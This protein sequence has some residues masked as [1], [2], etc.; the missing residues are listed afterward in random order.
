MS[1]IVFHYPVG[2]TPL[3][4]DEAQ[5]LIPAHLTTQ[6]QLNEWELRNILEAEEWA[7]S[8]THKALLSLD[9][10]RAL[11][12]RMFGET[13]RWAG[14]FRTKELN[15]G[16]VA[17]EHVAPQLSNLCADVEAQLEYKSWTTREIA[18]RLHHRLTH[19]HPFPNGNGRFSRMMADLLLHQ[20]DESRF[21]WGAT[22]L[23]TDGDVR[24]RYIAALQAADRRDLA[25][26]LIFLKVGTETDDA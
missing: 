13:W 3:D 22:S 1:R 20:L 19:I 23:G 24:S 9:F 8:R 18:A 21:E 15:L 10:I 14:K 17:A 7:F 16:F 25:P 26:L 6:A 4:P 11:H 5:G 2:A 12:K